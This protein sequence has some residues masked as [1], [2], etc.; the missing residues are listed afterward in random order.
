MSALGLRVVPVEQRPDRFRPADSAGRVLAAIFAAQTCTVCGEGPA[1]FY[2]ITDDDRWDGTQLCADEGPCALAAMASYHFDDTEPW[3]PP[4][5]LP[6]EVH[7]GD[8]DGLA[9]RI[10]S[11][12]DR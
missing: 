6:P 8:L 5:P 7:S 10:V 2:L 3:V 1:R 12:W 9:R 11:E 4:R